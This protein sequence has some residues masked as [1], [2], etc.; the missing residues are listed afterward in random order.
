MIP[1]S[2]VVHRCT[3]GCPS[4]KLE[5]L[6]ND[7][8]SLPKKNLKNSKVT[9]GLLCQHILEMGSLIKLHF[10]NQPENSTP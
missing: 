1:Y 3:T 2:P 7:S 8:K 5:G 6:I 9:I 4:S 10:H